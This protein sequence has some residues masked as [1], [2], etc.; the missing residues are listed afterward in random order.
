MNSPHIEVFHDAAKYYGLKLRKFDPEDVLHIMSDGKKDCWLNRSSTEKSSHISYLIADNK[1]L[2]VEVLKKFNISTTEQKCVKKYKD[3]ISFYKKHKPVVVKPNSSSL[4][5]GVTVG[6]N[7]FTALKKAFEHA[8]K[9]DSR[10]LVEN[11]IPGED[12][13][14]TVI[15]YKKVYV[16][17]RIPAYVLGDGNSTVSQLID[18]KNADKKHFKKEI[19][20]DSK[21]KLIL[22][23]QGFDLNSVLKIGQIVYLRRVANVAEG[24]T[25]IEVTQQASKKLKDMA[26]SVAKALKLRTAGV[27]I[28]TEDVSKNKGVVIE[29]NPRAHVVVHHYPHVG[30]PTYPARAIVKMLFPG[31]KKSGK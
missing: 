11:F 9:Y 30:K 3:L 20:K 12:Y 23:S 14:F 10:V 5:K 31:A 8:R 19:K 29:V 17:K 2:T 26:I 27:D 28:M 6:V 18:D 1:R 16:F 25:S 21:S 22:Q 7:S 15:D 13:R 24:G 4:G